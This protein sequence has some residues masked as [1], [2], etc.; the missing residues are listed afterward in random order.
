MDL[1]RQLG[2]SSC[3]LQKHF[4]I[5]ASVWWT[6][7][8]VCRRV[9]DVCDLEVSPPSLDAA[10]VHAA[11]QLLPH[12]L[13]NTPGPLRQ[14]PLVQK[15]LQLTALIVDVG[16]AEGRSPWVGAGEQVERVDKAPAQCCVGTQPAAL[17]RAVVSHG[18]VSTPGVGRLYA[19]AVC[20]QRGCF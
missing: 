1:Y 3:S 13:P 7:A 4:I 20:S 16:A 18:L 8:F 6:D 14:Q 5:V 17:F 10:V 12:Y 15:A 2:A 19:G 9:V 11:A